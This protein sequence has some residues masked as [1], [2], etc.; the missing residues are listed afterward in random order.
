MWEEIFLIAQSDK[1]GENR[2]EEKTKDLIWS[3]CHEWQDS[4]PATEWEGGK[5]TLVTI[6]CIG[7]LLGGGNGKGGPLNTFAQGYSSFG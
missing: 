7:V 1:K 3:I 5:E 4:A 2:K 6:A